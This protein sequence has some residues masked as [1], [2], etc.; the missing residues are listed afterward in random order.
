MAEVLAGWKGPVA[1]LTFDELNTDW[2]SAIARAYTSLGLVLTP[3]AL[4]AMRRVMAASEAGNHHAHAEQ[5][6]RFS[7]GG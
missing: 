6:A 5:L 3:G 4:A 1:R 2:E 7:E